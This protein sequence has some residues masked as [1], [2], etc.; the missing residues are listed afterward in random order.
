[1]PSMKKIALIPSL[2]LLSFTLFSCSNTSV[3]GFK[4]DLYEYE[5]E[6]S[7]DSFTKRL[8]E[9]KKNYSFHDYIFKVS[10]YDRIIASGNSSF[11]RV[12]SGDS[13]SSMEK[14][15]YCDIDNGV[16]NESITN[17]AKGSMDGPGYNEEDSGNKDFALSLLKDGDFIIAASKTLNAYYPLQ[18]SFNDTVSKLDPMRQLFSLNISYDNDKFHYYIDGANSNALTIYYNEY[19]NQANSLMNENVYQLEFKDDEISLTTISVLDQMDRDSNGARMNLRTISCSHLSL[20][21][22]E[23]ELLKPDLSTYYKYNIFKALDIDFWGYLL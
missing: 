17:R 15:V 13:T 7:V 12:S 14:T 16:I 3:N 23:L 6:V 10:N 8:E 2:L 18:I 4:H 19:S 9:L 5:N 22:A 1:M 21:S 11:G 20:A